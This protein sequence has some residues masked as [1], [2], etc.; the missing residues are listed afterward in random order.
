MQATKR[1]KNENDCPF[2]RLVYYGM[3]LA[4]IKF[5]NILKVLFSNRRDECTFDIMSHWYIIKY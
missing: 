4:I 3:G 2:Q 1:K 5:K